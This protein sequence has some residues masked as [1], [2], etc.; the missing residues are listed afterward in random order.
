MKRFRTRAT[1]LSILVLLAASLQLSAQCTLAI[2]SAVSTNVTCNGSSNGTI[3]VYTH[4]GQGTVSYSSGSGG[5]IMATQQFNSNVLVT[6]S[7]ASSSQ[8]F[9]PN[10]HTPFSYSATGGCTGGKVGFTGSFT[11]YW[12]NFLR[13]PQQDC[14]GGG[15]TVVLS[16]DLSNSYIASH[17]VSSPSS[18]DAMRF[19]V[20]DNNYSS[21]S[22]YYKASS[23]KIGGTEVSSV[24]GNGT[25]L[26]FDQART[27][28]HVDV[29]FDLTTIPNSNKL[30]FYIEASNP[31]NDSY[32]Y[33]VSLDNITVSQG[34]PSQSSNVYSG[35][36]PGTYTI[37]VTDS[38]GCTASTSAIT[39]TQP[40]ALT[41]G[42]SSISPTTVGGT[43]GSATATPSGGTSPYTY[44]WNTTPAQS[45]ATANNLAAGTYSVTVTDAH[46]CTASTSVVVAPHSCTGLGFT[47]VTSTNVSCNGLADGTIT[48]AGTGG[49]SPYQYYLNSNPAQGSGSFTGLAAATYSVHIIDNAGCTATYSN[50]ITITQPA[51]LGV[52]VATINATTQG[53]SDGTATA[54]V[55]GGTATYTYLWSNGATAN[56]IT[57]LSA[58]SYCVTVTDSHGCTASACGTVSQPS[59]NGFSVT[60]VTQVNVTCHGANDGIITVTATGGTTPYQYAL[61]SGNYQSGSGFSNLAAGTY[62]VKVKDASACTYTYPTTITITEPAALA[63]SVAT[64]NVTTVGG[65][66]GTATATVTGGTANYAY[67]WSNSATTNSIAGLTA[68][69]YCVTVTDDNFCTATA[70]G[71]VSQ[72]SCPNITVTPSISNVSCNGLADGEITINANGGASPYQYQLNNGSYQSGNTFSNLAAGTYILHVK[73]NNQCVGADT[74]TVSQPTVLAVSVTATNVTVV[75]GND[76]TA[77]ATVTGGTPAYTYFWSNNATTNQITGLPTGNYCVTVTDNHGC[78]AVACGT[79]A[80]PNC[81]GINVSAHTDSVHCHGGADGA[82]T[83]TATGGTS[84]YQYQLNSS[85]YQ[86]SNVFTGLAAGAYTITVKDANQCTGTTVVNV[87]EPAALTLSFNTVDASSSTATDGSDMAIVSG[88]TS[89][90]RYNWSDGDTANPITN[91][92]HGVYCVTVTDAFGCSVAGCDTVGTGGGNTGCNGLT[93]DSVR[94]INISCN[95]SGNGTINVYSHGG[96]GVVLYSINN[97]GNYQTANSFPNLAAGSYYVQIKDANNCVVSYTNNPV[98]ITEPSAVAPVATLSG[99]TLGTGAYS[100][101]QWYFNGVSIGA[102]ATS[103]TYAATQS[104]NYYVQVT[105]ANGCTGSSN[106]VPVTV[107]GIDPTNI[108]PLAVAIYPN[109]FHDEVNVV[110]DGYKGG[111]IEVELFDLFG[112]KLYQTTQATGQFTIATTSLAQGVYIIR[113]KANGQPVYRQIVKE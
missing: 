42:T 47:S 34:A 61:N 93:I 25:W 104:G 36:A 45:T 48:A 78:T 28:V 63:V 101:Y 113:F 94:F 39:I 9:A 85:G 108:S 84:P 112:R 12:G 27:C 11:N 96:S 86:S 8:W 75:G 26:K 52:S 105:D 95:G 97:G 73:D 77:T 53:G 102:T 106:V 72:P 46:N 111:D 38:A 99:N 68:G 32:T 65:S 18:S 3:T 81:P 57:G 92:A 1:L 10:S 60:N 109:P 37:T 35:L 110:V 98:N 23:V 13:S 54:T 44:S 71:T 6:G 58:G 16:F 56:P 20:W 74:V 87:R 24:D 50:S 5:V 88:G 70:C 91:I 19:Y 17:I 80:Q 41:V 79:V 83:I 4:G 90:Y 30:L 33:S 14:S 59:C 69:T 100:S 43:N 21:G 89:P 15:N 49:T 40:A 67:Q 2:D 82:T 31:Y 66:D 55:T 64:T 51:V 76:G 62:T 103:Q 29:T 22:H 7:T 107:T